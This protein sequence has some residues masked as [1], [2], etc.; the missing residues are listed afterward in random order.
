MVKNKNSINKNVQPAIKALQNGASDYILK[1]CEKD[2][3]LSRIS[4]CLEKKASK[5]QL[6][7][8]DEKLVKMNEKL[9]TEISL[10]N[11]SETELKKNRKSFLSICVN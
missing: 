3:F 1:P 11:D 9:K 2:E 8:N 10:R 4:Q 6:R 7:Q 5:N